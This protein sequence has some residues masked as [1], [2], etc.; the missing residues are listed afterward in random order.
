MVTGAVVGRVL[1]GFID[2]VPRI[3]EQASNRLKTSQNGISYLSNKTLFI[4]GGTFRTN[5]Y[6]F[7]CSPIRPKHTQTMPKMYCYQNNNLCTTVQKL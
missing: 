5:N 4:Q 2:D 6:I 7:Q 3:G 1:S